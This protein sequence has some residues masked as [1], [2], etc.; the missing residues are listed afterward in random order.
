MHGV[1]HTNQKCQKMH[2]FTTLHKHSPYSRFQPLKPSTSP[3]LRQYS[4]TP[5]PPHTPPN[6]PIGHS[7]RPKSF[8]SHPKCT[9]PFSLA[10][11]HAR[12]PGSSGGPLRGEIVTI[13]AHTRLPRGP[14][15]KRKRNPGRALG[16]PAFLFTILI[17]VI[18]QWKNHIVQN[19]YV[20]SVT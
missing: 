4:V 20:F 6:H 14:L 15:S 10:P 13:V 17:L 7:T 11:T 8:A 16:G 5:S 18:F 1:K 9:T 2:F 12:D 3:S 19:A